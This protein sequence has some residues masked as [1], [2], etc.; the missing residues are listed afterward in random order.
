[1]TN[2]L[3]DYRKPPI[4]EVALSVQFSPIEK[5]RVQYLGLLWEWFNNRFDNSYPETEEHPPLDPIPSPSG[6]V[7]ANRIG[8][9][10][11]LLKSPIIPRFW[12]INR[13]GSELVQVQA[14]RFIF[15]W[16]KR[17]GDGEYRRFQHMR[18]RFQETL[19]AF[20]AFLT[21]NRLGSLEI[22]LCELAYFNHISL[23]ERGPRNA[24]DV[25]R[26]VRIWNQQPVSLALPEPTQASL[27]VRYPMASQDNEPTGELTVELRPAFRAR[28][29]AP[30]IAMNLI[31]R[32]A[33]MGV[34]VSGA[35][36]FFDT[37]HQWVVR[38]F[39]EVTT[40]EMHEVW[41][42]VKE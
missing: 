9:R 25:G 39:V 18:G 36:A 3:P 33:P 40:P 38:S 23:G 29:K 24:G 30:I 41:E 20:A 21:E 13:S 16:R 7:T 28:D 35:L 22:R 37:G 4:V 27:T 26:I 42:E 1:M 31:A 2:P 12:M 32:G 11:E 15:N 10:L 19:E 14:D 8:V 5:W 6:R 17:N 34:G